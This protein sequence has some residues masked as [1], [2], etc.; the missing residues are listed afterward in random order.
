MHSRTTSTPNSR[1]INR[2][3]RPIAQGGSG[4]NPFP[5]DYGG[6]VLR[7]F[8][9][10][11]SG[12]RPIPISPGPDDPNR[13][14]VDGRS[15]LGVSGADD[16]L[17]SFNFTNIRYAGGAVPQTIGTR[18]DAITLFNSRPSITNVAIN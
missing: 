5:G 11:S 18:F 13:A 9:D 15:R 16:V 1:Q 2:D 10:T 3:G 14:Q 6:I 4:A 17:S 7:N 8:D 12:G